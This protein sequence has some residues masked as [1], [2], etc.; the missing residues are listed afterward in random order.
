MKIWHD[1]IRRPPDDSWY[2]CRTNEEVILLMTRSNF[3]WYT[4]TEISMD[5]DLGLHNEDP[6]E[7]E[8]V[9]RRGFGEKT[10]LDLVKWLIEND[11][12]PNKVTIHSWNPDG[13]R[14]MA[15]MLNH[16]GYDCIVKPYEPKGTVRFD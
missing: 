3:P 15:A 13:A 9:F 7:L 12:V 16:H 11:R 14:Y 1:D 5:H 4:I 6:D 10:G 2:W 8:A